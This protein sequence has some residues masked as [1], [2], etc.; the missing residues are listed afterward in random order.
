MKKLQLQYFLSYESFTLSRKKI[1]GSHLVNTRG[2]HLVFYYVIAYQKV[3]V[4]HI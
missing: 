4:Q 3:D 2:S 1:H